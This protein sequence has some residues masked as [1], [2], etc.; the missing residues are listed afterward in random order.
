MN[1]AI[2]LFGY[3]GSGKGTQGKILNGLPGF[4]HLVVRVRRT[5]D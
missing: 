5:T 1:R 3:P 4:H 2:L